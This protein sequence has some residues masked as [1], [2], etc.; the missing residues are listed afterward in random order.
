MNISS[1]KRVAV[2]RGGPSHEYDVSLRTGGEVL[3]H[4][5]EGYVG[6]DVLID[7]A[8]VWHIHGLPKSPEKILAHADVVF[9]ALHGHF[10][11][12]GKVHHI[13]E[14]HGMPHTG[15]PV[16]PSALGMNKSLAKN[17]FAKYGIR[18]PHF[19]TLHKDDM[20]NA[21]VREIFTTLPHPAIVKPVS[22][23][24]SLGVKLVTTIPELVD[25]LEEAFAYGEK[26]VVEEYISGREATCGVIAGYRDES[27]YSL[28]VFEVKK[29]LG[30]LVHTFDH[31]INNEAEFSHQSLTPLEK[32]EAKRTALLAHKA[33]GLSHYS[34]AD[35]IVHPKRGVYLLEVNSQPS[36]A[37]GSAFT[38]GL[39]QVGSSLSHF[40][41][42]VLVRAMKRV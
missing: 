9:N 8:G 21:R 33:L 35:M 41:D 17:I 19:E 10:G 29:P 2:L 6:L 11:E 7:K 36:L 13:L 38:Y 37:L 26:V 15:S 22:G 18:T 25:A 5:P 30:D 28:P 20:T 39:E 23:G 31:K 42:H 4:L 12:D 40:L 16:L 34:R 32:A 3:K 27:L 24:S 14:M 1:P